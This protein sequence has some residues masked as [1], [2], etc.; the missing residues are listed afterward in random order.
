MVFVATLPLTHFGDISMLRN[1]DSGHAT[2]AAGALLGAIG[3]VLLGIGAANGTGW[4]A[5]GGG[6]LGAVGLLGYE[7]VRHT[8]FDY[9]VFRHIDSEDKT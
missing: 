1:G 9:R 5:I 3:L 4:M 2:T 6:I 7:I 8:Q